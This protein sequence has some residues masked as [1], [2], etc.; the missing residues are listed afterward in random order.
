[1][2]GIQKTEDL[3]GREPEPVRSVLLD[4]PTETRVG[5]ELDP[6]GLRP[7][8][9]DH[10]PGLDGELEILQFPSGASNLTYLLRVGDRE[11]VMRV[12]VKEFI[13]IIIEF[14]EVVWSY[15]FLFVPTSLAYPFFQ[16]L[17][18]VDL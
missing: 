10:L 9:E 15:L 13:V 18:V 2:S 4:R 6:S 14:L 8:L 11:F 3:A 12:I 7:F 5:E 16:Y 17:D 1:M